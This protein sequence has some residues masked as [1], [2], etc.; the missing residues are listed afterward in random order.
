MAPADMLGVQTDIF[1]A[2]SKFLAVP[3]G[4]R[5]RQARGEEPG[6][7][8]SIALLRALGRPHGQGRARRSHLAGVPAPA[9][10]GGGQRSTGKGQLYEY[11]MG[12][13]VIGKLLRER[14]DG[15][16]AITMRR[17]S[18]RW[19]TAVDEANVFRGD[20]AGTMEVRR[21]SPP[22]NRPPVMHAAM[23]KIPGSGTGSI[24]FEFGRAHEWIL[25]YSS[26]RPPRARTS[27]RMNADLSDWDR[28]LLNVQ[29]DNRVSHFPAIIKMSGIVITTGRVIRFQKVVANEYPRV[30]PT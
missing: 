8:P 12:P 27:M 1:S 26:S 14:P 19:W 21:V 18:A 17:C 30:R 29:V 16:S 24:F 10:S 20:S 6:A 23:Q 5:L 7:R 13:A 3:K 15:W 28:S 22:R 25:D 4:S 2:F 11:A 9:P